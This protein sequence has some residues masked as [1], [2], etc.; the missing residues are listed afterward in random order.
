VGNSEKLGSNP[1][2]TTRING[3]AG[4]LKLS[5]LLELSLLRLFCMAVWPNV[6]GRSAPKRVSGDT[7]GLS[8]P[9]AVK[10]RITAESSFVDRVDR[11]STHLAMDASWNTMEW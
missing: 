7:R 10:A 9:S 11:E 1:F 3:A 2:R 5:P 6:R 4:T 8:F